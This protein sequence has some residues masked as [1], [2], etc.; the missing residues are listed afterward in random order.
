MV[1]EPDQ[2]AL[3]PRQRVP[4][5]PASRPTVDRWQRPGGDGQPP[6][7]GVESE[8]RALATLAWLFPTIITAGLALVRLPWPGL[9]NDELTYWGFARTPWHEAVRLLPQLDPT[10]VPYQVFLHGWAT[11]AGTSEF[12]LRL[13]SVIAMAAAAGMAAALSRRLIGPRGGLLA[14]LLFTVVPAVSRYGQNTGPQAMLAAAAVLATLALVWHFDESATESSWPS[15]LGHVLAYVGSLAVLGLTNWPALVL[16]LVAHGATVAFMRPRIVLS[17]LASAAFGALPAV[18]LIYTADTAWRGH[19]AMTA[20]GVHTIDSGLSTLFGSALIG[21]VIVGLGLLAVSLRRPAVVFTAWAIVPVAALLVWQRFTTIGLA[22]AIF[23]TLAAWTGVAAM[24]LSRFPLARGIVAVTAVGLLGLPLQV[25]IRQADGHDQG[26]RSLA[27]VLASHVQ[28]GDAAIYGP[29]DAEALTAR[30][31]VAHYVPPG[32]RPADL[33]ATTAPRTD[34]HL[35]PIECPAVAK[36]LGTAARVWVIRV[37]GAIDPLQGMSA[38]KDGALR[39]G[40]A[41]AEQWTF[42]GLSLT[43]FVR[44]AAKTNG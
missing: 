16:L 11:V 22:P 24:N 41:V 2:T 4:T 38:A 21:G 7:S 42:P 8:E 43:L 27:G 9:S 39:V 30:D 3:L 40:Y 36:C 1:T 6:V 23:L 33:L 14:G 17:W 32:H 13:P 10:T 26:T 37:D 12:A 25:S 29:T 19:P 20:T 44:D 15:R 28:T 35:Y 31:I 18:W 5:A 34:G